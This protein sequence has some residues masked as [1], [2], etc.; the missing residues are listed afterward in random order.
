M[1]LMV[2]GHSRPEWMES[3]LGDVIQGMSVKL[4]LEV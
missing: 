1:G 2:D 4:F 3:C